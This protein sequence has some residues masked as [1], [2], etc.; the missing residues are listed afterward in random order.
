[1]RK[2]SVIS[3]IAYDAE[4]LPR[5][6]ES[7]YD[8][9]DEIVLGI[10]KERIS[11]SGNEYKFNEIEL[12][13]AL[14]KLDV[15]KKIKVIE[16]NFH[17]SSIPI[18]NDNHQRNF[19]K[20]HCTHDWVFS[21]DADE[22]LINP[23]E[24]FIDFCPLVEDYDIDLMFYWFL[25]YKET[26]DGTLFI[27]DA[28]RQHFFNEEVQGFATSKTNTFTYCRWTNNQK[29]IQS[30]LAILH[31]SFCREDAKLEL[32]RNNFGHSVE[33]KQDPF[34]D[35]RKQVG[36]GNYHQ[37]VN[38]KSSNMGPQ[39]PALMLVPTSDIE[40]KCKQEAAMVY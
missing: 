8:Y 33:S 4:M 35:I 5:S 10:D 20:Q 14:D 9:V 29:K 3:L 32:K 26:Q 12:W 21:F 23:R 24:F 37:L 19:L 15:D 27:S 22:V 31:Y 16:D 13:T 11:W 1:M 39:W 34:Y 2:K 38:F 6:I 7:Y 36:L 30:P 40:R 17:R 28:S 18:E 25:P